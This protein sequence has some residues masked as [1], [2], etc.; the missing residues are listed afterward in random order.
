MQRLVALPLLAIAFLGCS[1]DTET[2]MMQPPAPDPP[3]IEALYGPAPA[4][5]LTPY[6][7]DRYTIPDA[8]T[9][10]G[11]RVQIDAN[12][13][14]D[15]LVAAYDLVAQ[16]LS[17][18]DGF[19][20]AGGVVASFSGPIDVRGIIHDPFADPPITEPARDALDYTKPDAPFFLL[21]VDPKSPER[22]KARG[23]V[24]RWWAQAKDIDFPVDE[25]TLVA[26]PSVPLRPGTRYLFAVTNRLK[27]ADG[28]SIGRADDMNRLLEKGEDD[29]YGA[30]VKDA[31]AAME[32]SFGVSREDL[33]LASVFTTATVIDE[34]LALAERARSAPSPALGSPWEVETPINAPDTRVRF[35][36]VFQTPE[37][38]RPLPTG[39]WEIKDGKPV[40]QK[41]VGLEVFL[42]FSD[43]TQSGPRPIVIY[44]HG[45]GG[46]KD[47]NWGTAQRLAELNAAVIAIDSPEHGSRSSGGSALTWAFSFFGVDPS[48]NSFDI[49][50]ARD[51]FRQMTSDQLELVRFIKRLGTLDLLPVGA[52]DGVPD[53]DVS[54]IL[55]IGHSF[56]SVQGPAIFAL[57]PEITQA[58]WNVGGDGLMMLLRD[59]STFSLLV[60][61]LK[62]P[63]TPDGAMGRFFAVTQAIV[64]PGDPINFA[65]F[66]N[67]EA[68]PGVPDWKPRDVLLQE[69][70]NDSIVPNSTTEALARAAGL[71]LLDP[72][73]AISGLPSAKAPAT[74]NVAGGATGG[75]SQF[76]VIE[77]GQTAQHGELIFSPRPAPN[78]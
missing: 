10:T 4:T 35:R 58:T 73:S 56:G 34:T 77:G 1:S 30:E 22:G 60:N 72:K 39:T 43:A 37:Y 27:A 49:A 24:P 50:R 62:P 9:R 47:G 7:S 48:G 74:G 15:P 65:R 38:R 12:A 54:R 16:E 63:A 69:V 23:L 68:P 25:F 8:T 14:I 64:D 61:S 71:V 29:A 32:T 2:M 45:L 52:P 46:D 17:E 5:N 13:T 59:S 28:G 6:P 19:S 57:A 70:I 66:A 18:M 11:L 76:D 33:V 21:D 26:Q 42:A 20:T 36:A 3:S 53:L 51:N 75:I 31:L 41:E 78:T 40:Q 44:Q 55:Y 67:Q